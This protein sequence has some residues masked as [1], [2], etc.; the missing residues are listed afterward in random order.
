MVFCKEVTDLTKIYKFILWQ[1]FVKLIKCLNFEVDF[2]CSLLPI[3]KLS[4][5][6]WLLSISHLAQSCQFERVRFP[7][8]AQF[9]SEILLCQL[10]KLAS[11][12]FPVSALVLFRIRIIE[13][14][15][16][17]SNLSDALK[18]FFFV[19]IKSLNGLRENITNHTNAKR[20]FISCGR[21]L[22]TRK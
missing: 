17:V 18:L 22:S 8:S 11:I 10:Q 3:N 19:E 7:P 9:R 4:R 15:L 5:Q 13:I 12:R 21:Q 2:A 1:L 20:I 16:L 6:T 14:I